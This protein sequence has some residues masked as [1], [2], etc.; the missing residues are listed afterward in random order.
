M[1][2]PQENDN[3]NVDDGS[4]SASSNDPV[5]VATVPVTH[6]AVTPAVNAPAPVVPVDDGHSLNPSSVLLNPFTDGM[7]EANRKAIA[8]WSRLPNKPE[9]LDKDVND[10]DIKRFVWRL[11]RAFMMNGIPASH[12]AF[13]AVELMRGH[14]AQ[15]AMETFND[16]SLLLALSLDELIVTMKQA[17]HF[18]DDKI[19]KQKLLCRLPLDHSHTIGQKPSELIDQFHTRLTALITRAGITQKDVMLWILYSESLIDPRVREAVLA[20][21][22]EAKQLNDLM[23]I[24]VRKTSTL[25]P[26]SARRWERNPQ[27][28]PA[29][30]LAKKGED[31]M[32]CGLTRQQCM[33]DRLCMRCGASGH[34]SRDCPK[35]KDSKN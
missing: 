17:I 5:P 6:V 3:L 16:P 26:F 18:A 11:K 14:Y 33:D 25:P 9:L 24:A 8:N 32:P 22:P 21:L 1:S 35:K 23:K 4:G 20:A 10:S 15:W 30:A 27:T 2:Q 7:T 29:P 28:P 13:I 12:H 34:Q 19:P 31:V